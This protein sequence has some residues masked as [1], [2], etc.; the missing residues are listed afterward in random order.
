MK[1]KMLCMLCLSAMSSSFALQIHPNG[2][3]IGDGGHHHDGALAAA[4]AEF[5]IYE[6]AS[7]VYDFGCGKGDYVKKLVECGLN[8]RGFDGNPNTVTVT[9][10]LGAVLDLSKP[11]E[12]YQKADWVVSLEVGE[13]LPKK[14]EATF[15]QN[16]DRHN[17]KGIILSW[18]L[19]GQGGDGHFNEQNNDYVKAQ[20]AK[21]G[22]TNDVVAEQHLRDKARISWFK[23]TIMVFRK[24]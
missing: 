14:F 21:L 23:N 2:Y 19:K 15:L 4:I 7:L 12:L 11:F 17:T 6:E 18:A 16:L 9:G 22:Y 5:L 1:M 8:C 20:M 10:G 24:P 13:H 3:W